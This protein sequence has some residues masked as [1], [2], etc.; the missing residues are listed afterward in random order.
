VEKKEGKIG[1]KRKKGGDKG[2]FRRDRRG[3]RKIGGSLRKT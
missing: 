1:K 2:V 3:K